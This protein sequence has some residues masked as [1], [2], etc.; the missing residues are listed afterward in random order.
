MQRKQGEPLEGY[1]AQARAICAV[2]KAFDGW[3][4]PAHAARRKD[5]EWW[6]RG[7]EASLRALQRDE[8]VVAKAVKAAAKAAAKKKGGQG[9]LD[10]W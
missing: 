4:V 10:L 7:C 1:Q 5:E 6:R 3:V 8:G 9:D 2:K